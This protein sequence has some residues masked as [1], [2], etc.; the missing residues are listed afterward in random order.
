MLYCTSSLV[1]D[2]MKLFIVLGV[3]SATVYTPQC[4]GHFSLCEL[5]ANRRTRK[6]DYCGRTHRKLHVIAERTSHKLTANV[7]TRLSLCVLRSF[8]LSRQYCH[9]FRPRIL[10]LSNV[11]YRL[12]HRNSLMTSFQLLGELKFH[13]INSSNNLTLNDRVFKNSDI[14]PFKTR[15]VL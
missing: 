14:H 1:H 13:S 7:S 8:L 12:I 6:S 3:V 4:F 10:K 11:H 15:F 5:H 9:D 2:I